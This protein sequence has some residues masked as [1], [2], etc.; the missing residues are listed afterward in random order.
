MVDST[1]RSPDVGSVAV[2]AD[3]T[4]LNVCEILARR[5]RT[6]V[7]VDAVIRDT[8]VIEVRR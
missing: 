5:I 4:R 3:I 6:V 8:Y 1:D 2:L 7:A